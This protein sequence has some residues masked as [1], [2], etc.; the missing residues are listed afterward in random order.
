MLHKN[1]AYNRTWTD[2]LVLTKD[3]LYRLSYV[4]SLNRA[5]H[6]CHTLNIDF[7]IQFVKSG[8]RKILIFGTRGGTWTPKDCS[9]RTSTVRVCQ[10]RHPSTCFGRL[11]TALV[12]K[13]D[14]NL[15]H[16]VKKASLF[17]FFFDFFSFH[18]AKNLFFTFAGL[19]YYQY[20]ALFIYMHLYCRKNIKEG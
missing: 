17:W 5:W 3:V 6:F 7:R 2:D 19:T 18:T 4:G 9:I 16:Y 12:W 11:Q 13:R 10:F 8:T 20:W 1:G 14:F 15:S